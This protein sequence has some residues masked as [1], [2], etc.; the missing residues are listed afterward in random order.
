MEKEIM[1]R[2]DQLIGFIQAKS[3]LIW[4]VFY[5]QQIIEGI[6]SIIFLV[7]ALTPFFI[8]V[9]I[10]KARPKWTLDSDSLY[11]GDLVITVCSIIASIIGIALILGPGPSPITE[12]CILRSYG[13]KTIGKEE[14]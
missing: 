7:L 1:D 14:D 13:I 2:V 8:G 3:P 6:A 9:H 10:I 4:E 12:P 11:V 5:R